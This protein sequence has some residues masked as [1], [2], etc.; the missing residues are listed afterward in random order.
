MSVL[1]QRAKILTNLEIGRGLVGQ[2]T[3]YDYQ[4]TV[5]LD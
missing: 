4:S 1:T 5:K 2:L 3:I